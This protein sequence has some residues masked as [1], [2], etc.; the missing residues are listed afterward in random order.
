MFVLKGDE[1]G[2]NRNWAAVKEGLQ[3]GKKSTSPTVEPS[4]VFRGRRRQQ[5][6]AMASTSP[7]M[8]LNIGSRITKAGAKHHMDDGK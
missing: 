1:K 3:R 5:R 2:D 6:L 8:D 7:L 4:K